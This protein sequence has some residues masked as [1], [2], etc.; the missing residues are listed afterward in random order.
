MKK[1]FVYIFLP[2]FTCST[3]MANPISDHEQ[4][5]KDAET[6]V[7]LVT[8]DNFLIGT[9]TGLVVFMFS[10]S[11]LLYEV[12]YSTSSCQ[13]PPF[14]TG[15]S[16]VAS[17]LGT[18]YLM[19]IQVPA[20]KLLGKSPEYVY[21][22]TK[23]YQDKLRILRAGSAALGCFTGCI[24]GIATLNLLFAGSDDYPE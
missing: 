9:G 14:T 2:L 22:Y 13:W 12:H 15:S 1:V 24:V 16:L 21:V 7:E 20:A 6:D 19:R 3:I 17:A 11:V 18:L 23:T 5:I 10:L 8:V 4:A